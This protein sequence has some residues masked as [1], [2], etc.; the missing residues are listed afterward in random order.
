MAI[1]DGTNGPTLSLEYAIYASGSLTWYKFGDGSS[2]PMR[3]VMQVSIRRGRTREDQTIQPGVMNVLFDNRLGNY[4]PDNSSSIYKQ[5][6]VLAMAS[7]RL[8][9]LTATIGGST[10]TVF[11]GFIEMMDASVDLSPT[12]TMTVVDALQQLSKNVFTG[13]RPIE[14]TSTRLTNVLPASF[15]A[16]SGL[17]VSLSLSGYRFVQAQSYDGVN[18]GQIA[19][20]CVNADAG[21]LYVTGDNTLVFKPFEEFRSTK[22]EKFRLSDDHVM[23][24]DTTIE[25]DSVT[26]NVG[27][28]FLVNTAE[29]DYG[30]DTKATATDSGSISTYGTSQVS[31][32]NYLQ[33]SMSPAV[34][35]AGVLANRLAYPKTR[36][37]EVGFD[38]IGL[39][40]SLWQKLLSTELTDSVG[41]ERQTVD[42]RSLSYL[43]TLGAVN[44]D[45]KPDNWRVTL[46]LETYRSAISYA[47]N[48]T[49]NWRIFILDTDTLDSTRKLWF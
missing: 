1:Y 32:Q 39:S 23:A 16:L 11:T 10:Y 37:S 47:Y 43:N 42:G 4:D 49:T 21:Y 14:L 13:D 35:L 7:N 19:Q 18:L 31:V 24:G 48:P 44:H 12:V 46:Q 45:I 5:G 22:A 17:N 8:I 36:I 3:D 30:A 2:N 25:Y 20:D 33:N 38:A 26:S 40:T 28:K 6:S 41:L 27:A 9:R 15:T 29:V 34:G